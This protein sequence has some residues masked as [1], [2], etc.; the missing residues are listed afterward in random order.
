L[1]SNSSTFS[2]GE[3]VAVSFPLAVIFTGI[4]VR[5]LHGVSPDEPKEMAA[6]LPRSSMNVLSGE[7]AGQTSESYSLA[8]YPII[9]TVFIQIN[10]PYLPSL[11]LPENTSE[12]F[13]C[14]FFAGK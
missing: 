11:P 3:E 6:R 5:S 13:F 10:T 1:A 2:S 12:K 4:W 7:D 8:N 9:Q 14:F